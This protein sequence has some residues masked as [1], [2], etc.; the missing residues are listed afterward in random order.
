M[1]HL[2]KHHRAAGPWCVLV[3]SWCGFSSAAFAQAQL[4]QTQQQLDRFNQQMEQ[5]EQL[6]RLQVDQSIPPGDRMLIDYGGYFTAAYVTLDDPTGYNHA[7]R[8][9]ELVGYAD[10]NLDGANEFF[11]RFHSLYND[12]NPGDAFDG[13]RDD[14]VTPRIERAFY[15]FDLQKSEA[16]YDG[17]KINGDVV[18]TGGRHL[19]SWANG[20]VLNDTIDGL[21]TTLSSGNL[22]L[23]AVAG[24]TANF[25]T[26]FD[27][28]RPSFRTHTHR[29]FYGG[30]ITTQIAQQHLFIY[31]LDQ[32]DYND[33]PALVSHGITTN[34]KYNSFYLGLGGGGNITDNLLY[35]AE[36][37]SE[38]GTSLSNS[39]AGTLSPGNQVAQKYDKIRAFALD[40]RLSYAFADTDRSRMDGELILASGDNDRLSTSTTVGGNLPGTPDRAFNGFGLLNTGLSFAP[41][42]SNLLMERVGASTFPFQRSEW[43]RQAQV[44]VDGF[45]FEK[46]QRNAPIDEPT[47]TGRLLG[48]EA[49]AYLNWQITSDLSFAMRYG[50]FWGTSVISG[51]RAPRMFAYTGVTY[52]F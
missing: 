41:T 43:F 27:N 30:M 25:D 39:F 15:R 12:F 18:F 50:V 19:V 32:A 6:T 7:L 37:V 2:M 38:G 28:S 33:D 16:A 21:S 24:V 5:T 8:Q 1:K 51:D 29:G 23:D 52:A 45:L 40:A 48:T 3:L 17:K 22:S 47:T 9:F 46:A 26:D 13:R 44:G 14:Y 4:G 34:F 10:L 36:L 35:S 20:L 31:G 42:V 11:A 49:D